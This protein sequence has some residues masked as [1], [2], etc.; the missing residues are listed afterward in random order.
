MEQAADDTAAQ[1]IAIYLNT[2]DARTR[3]LF[4]RRYFYMESIETLAKCYGLKASTV[5]T[6]LVRTR[7]K[8]RAFLEQEGVAI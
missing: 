8:L 6:K 4:V 7:K 1:A 5:S 2:L 3:I